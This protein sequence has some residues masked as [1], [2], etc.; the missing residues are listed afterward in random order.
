M[1]GREVGGMANLLSAHRDLGNAAHRAEVAA[2]WGVDSVPAQPGK[3]A[4]EMF[5]AVA[6]GEIKCLWIACTNPAQSMP[7][8]N[9]VRAALEMAEMVVVQ[10]CFAGVDTVAYADVLLPATT[11][12]EKDG[13]V[14]NSERRIS[15]VLP[16]VPG[17]GSARHDWQIAIDFARALA[18]KLGRDARCSRMTVPNRSGTSIANPP[19]AA[20][21]DI[22]G[23]SYAMIAAAPQQWPLASGAAA[24]KMRSTRTV[25]FPTA[26][27]RARFSR[28]CVPAAGRVAGRP[29]PAAP[30]HR[31][32]ARPV[33]RH[34][35]H[36]PGGAA[37]PCARSRCWAC[38]PTTWRA[39]PG[40]R[41]VARVSTRRGMMNVRVAVSN[42]PDPASPT[43]RCTGA[44]GSPAAAASMY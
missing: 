44:A 20:T 39:R 4:V 28:L 24:G 34:V 8:Q 38:M 9:L 21:L 36:R 35:A 27:G 5:E 10:E 23:M 33:A 17:P 43:C 42:E 13:T 26:S 7:D 6:R 22:T 11:W 37:V 15:R 12:G 32:A 30:H 14:T 41:C 1:G 25:Y 16:A 18:P 40:G 31:P 3:T 19:A 29:V 2:L